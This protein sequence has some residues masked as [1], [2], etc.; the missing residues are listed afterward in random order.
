MAA[1]CEICNE[2][3]HT[4][5]CDYATNTGIVTTV[6]FQEMTEGCDKKL[7]ADCAVSLW[8]DCDVCPDHANQIKIRLLEANE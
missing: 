1:L 4:R 7:C 5:L 8:A 2:R 6:D 3:E